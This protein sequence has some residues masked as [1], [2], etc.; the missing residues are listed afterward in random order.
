MFAFVIW[1]APRQCL[2]LALDRYGKKPLFLFENN[3]TFLFASEIKSILAFPDVK[4]EVD[5]AAVWDYF[6]YRWLC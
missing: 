6:A 2:F 3:A 4:P 5:T 1:D